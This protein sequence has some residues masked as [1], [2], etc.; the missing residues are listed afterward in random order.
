MSEERIKERCKREDIAL[1]IVKGFLEKDCYTDTELEYSLNTLLDLYNKQKEEIKELNKEFALNIEIHKRDMRIKELEEVNNCLH[2]T[3]KELNLENQAFYEEMNCDDNEY[4][5]KKY[6]QLKSVVEILANGIRVLGTNPDITTEEIIKEF[7]ENPISEEYI[8]EFKS[9]YISKNKIKDNIKE[10]E[11]LK[12]T[13]FA[14]NEISK[15]VYKE[16]IDLINMQINVLKNL[17]EE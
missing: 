4:I 14:N 15:Q 12:M 13:S 16:Q 7:T 9:R 10:L 5:S 2:E 17:L 6:S 8:K 1:K 3:N 11:I